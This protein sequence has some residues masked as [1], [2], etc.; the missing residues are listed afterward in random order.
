MTSLI[1][2]GV[3]EKYPNLRFVLNEYSLAWLP[4]LL[5]SLDA[6]YPTL[7]RESPWVRRPP[8][9]YVREF[10]RFSTQ[11]LETTTDGRDL[12]TLLSAYDGIE[13]LLCFSSDYP[14]YTMDDFGFAQR[15]LPAE[16]HE[17]VFY[18]NARNFYR[19]SDLPAVADAPRAVEV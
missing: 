8:S 14:H 5:W 19:W 1:V 4:P 16:W 10:I 11:P 6:A 3:F 18:E 7:K 17:K 9:E 15:T 12:A 2:H 13:D